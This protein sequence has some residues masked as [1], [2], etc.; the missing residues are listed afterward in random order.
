MRKCKHNAHSAHSH[1][2]APDALLPPVSCV[3]GAGSKVYLLAAWGHMQWGKGMPDMPAS[4]QRGDCEV[5]AGLS[6]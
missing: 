2:A 5:C 1:G 3:Q 6:L 4:P